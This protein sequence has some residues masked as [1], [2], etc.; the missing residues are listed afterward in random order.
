M[1]NGV[2][3]QIPQVMGEVAGRCP[4]ACIAAS[5]RFGA[6]FPSR[7]KILAGVEDA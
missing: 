3:E 5:L 1:C 7:P 2:T 4:V 6:A